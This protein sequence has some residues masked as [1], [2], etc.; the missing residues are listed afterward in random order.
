MVPAVLDQGVSSR[1]IITPATTA[2]SHLS[3]GGLWVDY[4]TETW[5]EIH[6]DHMVNDIKGKPREGCQG[7]TTITAPHT[8]PT[9]GDNNEGTAMTMI[10][11]WGKQGHQQLH[12]NPPTQ[13]LE[14]GFFGL[15]TH[16]YPP[17]V[18]MRG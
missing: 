13:N 1:I 18:C 6:R 14:A 15:L 12:H 9:A 17:H 5:M 3:Q 7:S 2:V 4:R 10:A 11:E 16:C 8:H